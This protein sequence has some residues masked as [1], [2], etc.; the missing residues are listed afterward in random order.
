MENGKIVISVNEVAKAAEK[1]Q[2]ELERVKA[3]FG[4]AYA[5]AQ[6]DFEVGSEG[7]QRLREDNDAAVEMCSEMERFIDMMKYVCNVYG[8]CA[9]NIKNMIEEINA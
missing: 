8:D 7:L 1:M 4:K 3:A 9:N 6:R 2:S 5:I